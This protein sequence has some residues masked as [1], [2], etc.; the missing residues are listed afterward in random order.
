MRAETSL[1]YSEVS[2]SPIRVR[3]IDWKGRC[4]DMDRHLIQSQ[5]NMQ[6][7]ILTGHQTLLYSTRK[8]IKYI[9][10]PLMVIHC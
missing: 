5:R 4:P 6:I 10:F 7:L 3:H 8:S 9:I 2:N 1:P